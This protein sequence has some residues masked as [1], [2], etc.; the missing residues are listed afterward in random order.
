M[1]QVYLSADAREQVRTAQA[2]LDEHPVSGASD[3]CLTCGVEGSC[4]QR[5]AALR[6]LG[7]YGRLPL[8]R[9]GATRP[10]LLDTWRVGGRFGWL[11]SRDGAKSR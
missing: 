6:L 3:L 10:E 5:R 7:R 2:R 11:A 8:R 4:P 9:P 1:S